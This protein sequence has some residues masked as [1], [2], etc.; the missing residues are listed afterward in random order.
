M[1]NRAILNRAHPNFVKRDDIYEVFIDDST[2]RVVLSATDGNNHLSLDMTPEE[3]MRL[4]NYLIKAYS[5]V[6][7]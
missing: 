6:T 1:L 7:H 2:K 5:K 3:A 4:A